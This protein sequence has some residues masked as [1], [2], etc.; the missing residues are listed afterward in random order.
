[1]CSSL[2]QHVLG[3]SQREIMSAVLDISSRF[4]WLTGTSHWVEP[5][6]GITNDAFVD[7]LLRSLKTADTRIG[8]H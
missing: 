2:L 3:M 1:M 5:L 6:F 7:L 8:M 4:G